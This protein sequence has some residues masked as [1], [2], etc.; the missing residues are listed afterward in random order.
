MRNH[1]LVPA[2]SALFA[3][4]AAPALAASPAQVKAKITASSTYEGEERHVAEM[5]FDGNLAT[6]W[7]EGKASSGKNEWIEIAW[8]RPQTIH[9][10]SIWAGDFRGTEEWEQ[11][12]RVA[13]ALISWWTKEGEGS[14]EVEIGDRF[15]RK[16][17]RIDAGSG[18]TRVRVTIAGIHIG[19]IFDDTHIAEVAFN[20]PDTR[21]DVVAALDAW[22]ADRRY[23]EIVK[24][25][26]EARDRA[27]A[28]AKAGQEYEANLKWLGEAVAGG[29][30]FLAEKLA[31]I[32]PAGFRLQH[33]SVDEKAVEALRQLRDVRAVPYLEMAAVRSGADVAARLRRLVKELQAWEQLRTAAKAPVPN[34]GQRGIAPG[35]FLSRGE[36]LGIDVT[37]QGDIV[38]ADIGNNRVQRFTPD[39]RVDAVWGS[40]EPTIADQ[41]FGQY[42]EPYATGAAP[43]EGPGQFRQPQDLAVGNYDLVAVIDYDKRVQILDPEG[44]QVA[45]FTIPSDYLVLPGHG[46]GT[47]IVSWWDDN[48]Y[49]MLGDEVWGYSNKGEQLVR[50]K[51]EDHILAGVVADGKL[52]VRTAASR[53]LIEYAIQDGFRQGRFN[54]KPIE[55]DGSE[56]W[57]LATDAE[58]NVYLVTDVGT[59]IVW[60]KKGKLLHKSNVAELGLVRPRIAV[61]GDV[62]Y[63]LSGERIGRL[64][65]P[66][67]R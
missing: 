8:D 37:S 16:D 12:N 31:G 48:F 46:T 40:G 26:E 56:D 2:A 22:K 34:W 42:T 33:L 19:S 23:P 57:D 58:D 10:V 3:A 24:A 55:E 25:Y 43:G 9:T 44:K 4:V 5:A 30:P 14:R 36:A 29:A 1:W 15:A 61:S 49:F 13:K 64:Q 7:A 35:A 66:I 63:V 20:F 45:T 50:F 51:V 39:G 6:S 60:N 28:Q 65:N 47:P 38:V 53:D 62:I 32:A 27:F 21:P 41:W 52:L 59:L 18:V 67:A 11:R 54:R 17:V